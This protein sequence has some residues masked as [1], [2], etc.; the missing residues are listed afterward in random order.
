MKFVK[1]PLLFTLLCSLYIF[2]DHPSIHILEEST[3]KVYDT[4]KETQFIA[5]E[6]RLTLASY[7]TNGDTLEVRKNNIRKNSKLTGN[8]I[9]GHQMIYDHIRTIFPNE[10]LDKYV[11][12]FVVMTDGESGY[13]AFV[14]PNRTYEEWS[15][16]IDL[17][18]YYAYDETTQLNAIPTLIHE[19]AHIQTLNSDELK[20]NGK[21]LDDTENHIPEDA[22]YGKFI[23][24][25][26]TEDMLHT[27]E[28][29]TESSGNDTEESL[30]KISKVLYKQES[31]VSKYASTEPSEDVAESITSFIL[32]DKPTGTTTRDKKILFFYDYPEL[33]K[34]RDHVRE[35]IE[36]LHL[37]ELLR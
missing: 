1:I 5:K 12:K 4:F 18:D 19:I 11:N 30:S 33:V 10:F 6:E 2:H 17:A 14:R 21:L 32:E 27:V 35:G 23:K 34:Y 28:T 20:K 36:E 37:E 16:N 15:I 29:I 31:F 22:M 3:P 26:W 24:A 7:T 8:S 9:K 25:F 13:L